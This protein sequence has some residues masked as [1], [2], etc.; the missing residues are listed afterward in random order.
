MILAK[1]NSLE[2]YDIKAR[3]KSEIVKDYFID[4]IAGPKM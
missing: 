1:M 3:S 2:G 4:L